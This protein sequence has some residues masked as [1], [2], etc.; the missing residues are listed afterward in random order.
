[1][2]I[3]PWI[4]VDLDGTL[5][6]YESGNYHHLI[7]GEPVPEMVERI[8][9]FLSLGLQVKIMTARC[10]HDPDGEAVKVIEEW[11]FE[12]LGQILPVTCSKDYGMLELYDDRVV[13]VEMNTGKIIGYSRL[14]K[15]LN[16]TNS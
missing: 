15:D 6:K 5:A 16:E 3:E 13:Q 4:G 8:K 10:S 12:H 2:R 9:K 7:I 14:N 11:C 1:M